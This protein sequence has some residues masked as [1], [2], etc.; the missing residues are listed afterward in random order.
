MR[1]Y[2]RHATRYV[3]DHPAFFGLQQLRK[4]PKTS[5]LQQVID[6]TTT[7][8]GGRRE[9]SFEDHHHNI[10]ELVSFER[11]TTRLSIISEG[12]VEVSDTHGI[13]GPHRGP[14]PLW[15]YQRATDRT[16][17]GAGCR[18]LLRAVDGDGDLA[19]LHALMQVIKDRVPYEIGVSQPDW[20]AED[21]LR[22]GR[23]V[24]QDH[25]H[26]FIACARDMGFPARYVSGYLL[27][28]DR[29]SQDASHAWAEAHIDG[30]GW[31]GF[32]VSNGISPDIRYVRVATGLDYAD[33]APVTGTRFGGVGESLSVE[34]EVAQQ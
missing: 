11:G 29:V 22:E 7:I 1:L 24:C 34:I 15:L 32:D 18:K 33:A 25:A 21:A 8:E 28:D 30:L 3:F 6:W 26:I 13:L 31:V 14:A 4:T 16:R 27:M 17:A 10:V 5:G 20:G 9:L 12:A 23:G 19:R 2:I